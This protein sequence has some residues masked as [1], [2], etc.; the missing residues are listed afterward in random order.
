MFD[1]KIVIFEGKIAKLDTERERERERER[2]GER[3]R[4][5]DSGRARDLE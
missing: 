4:D 5:K 1:V 2:G 3:G